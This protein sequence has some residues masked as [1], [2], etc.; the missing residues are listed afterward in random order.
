MTG[1]TSGWII[2]ATDTI[3]KFGTNPVTYQ[4]SQAPMALR[5]NGARWA[6]EALPAPDQ[7]QVG[8]RLTAV[9]ASGPR[10][11]WIDGS[12]NN[13]SF[14]VA[15]ELASDH[16]YLIHYD[17]VRWT[18]V[19]LPP[20]AALNPN[21]DATT[22]NTASFPIIAPTGNGGLWIAGGLN[23]QQN[24][25]SSYRPL[26]YAYHGGQWTTIPLPK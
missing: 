24:Q 9:A 26:L 23:V 14:T 21:H 1:P 6:S 7:T 22:F 11:V 19:A 18:R 10:D 3:T 25:T 2:G 5:W 12:P 13:S 16:D 15:S 20:V 4:A 17:G 8:L